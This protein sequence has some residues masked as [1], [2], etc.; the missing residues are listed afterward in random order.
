MSREFEITRDANGTVSRDCTTAD[1]E[2]KGG[3]KGGVW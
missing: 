3:C 2:D 1:G